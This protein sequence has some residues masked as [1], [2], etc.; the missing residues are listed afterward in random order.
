MYNFDVTILEFNPKL[1]EVCRK[2]S[3]GDVDAPWLTC[4]QGEGE[5]HCLQVEDNCWEL[6]QFMQ[7]LS[8]KKKGPF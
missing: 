4:C 1:L 3:G 2:Y 6:L 7:I 5:N 8:N